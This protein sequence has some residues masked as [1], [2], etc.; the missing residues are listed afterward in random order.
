M[1]T[2]EGR[3]ALAFLAYAAVH[4]EVGGELRDNARALREQIAA[5]VGDATLTPGPAATGLLALLDGLGMQVLTGQLAPD[6]AVA[7]F[8]A[9]LKLVLGPAE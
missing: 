9:Y 5:R 2:R 8:D 3:V 4:P 7:A 6:D 1:R